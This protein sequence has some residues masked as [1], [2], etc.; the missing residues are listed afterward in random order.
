MELQLAT[1]LASLA[2]GGALLAL[3]GKWW[4]PLADADRRVKELADAVDALLRL[5]AEVLGHDPAPASDPVRAWLR[6]VRRRARRLGRRRRGQD[7]G[8]EARARGVRPRRA[9]RPRPARGGVQGLH[10]GQ[11]PEGGRVRARAAGRAHGAGAGR[12]D[13]ELPEGQE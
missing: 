7:H 12:W 3:L 5:R 1:V 10:G 8:A 6:R 13:P 2:L 11:A 9:L 4:Q